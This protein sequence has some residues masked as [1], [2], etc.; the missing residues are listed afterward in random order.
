MSRQRHG[1]GGPRDPERR[2]VLRLIGLTAGAVMTGGCAGDVDSPV[3]RIALADL[4]EGQRIDAFV[5]DEPV[6][7]IRRGDEVIA[8]SLW[9]THMGCRVHW[10]PTAERYQ[11]PCHDGRFGAEGEVVGGPPRE[12]LR[13]MA[14]R[15]ENGT[16]LVE[17]Q[18]LTP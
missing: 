2:S 8:R 6:Q 17:V 1:C 10:E 3:L 11:C 18:A 16:V 14:V 5:G 15:I 4:P 9:C 13:Q 7:L 12:P